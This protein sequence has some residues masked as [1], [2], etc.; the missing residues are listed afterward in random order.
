MNRLY[1]DDQ[2]IESMPDENDF[3][4]RNCRNCGAPFHYGSVHCEY[5]GTARCLK[6]RKMKSEIIINA[7]SIRLC[8]Y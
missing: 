3:D 1:A 8:A 4:D 5:C 2:L 7:D 6:T